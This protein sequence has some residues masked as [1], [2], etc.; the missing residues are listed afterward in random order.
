DAC[1]DRLKTDQL[2]VQLI[3]YFL[4]VG[5]LEGLSDVEHL[6]L[7]L[8]VVHGHEGPS[9]LPVILSDAKNLGNPSLG[10]G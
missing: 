4:N 7:C 2:T 9:P 1:F 6:V 3:Q 8:R 10:S 5:V